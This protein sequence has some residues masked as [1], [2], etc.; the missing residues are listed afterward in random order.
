MPTII[1]IGGMSAKA[2]GFGGG[3]G[4]LGNCATYITPGTYSWVAPSGVT[5]VSVVAVGAGGSSKNVYNYCCCGVPVSIYYP[6]GGGGG[7][8]WKNNISVTPGNSYTVVVGA[9]TAQSIGGQS[10]FINCTTVAGLG[11]KYCNISGYGGGCYVGTGGGRGGNG[12]RNSCGGGKGGGGGGGYSGDGGTGCCGGGAGAGGGGGGGGYGY[13]AV[14]HAGGGGGGV[15]LYGQGTSGGSLSGDGNGRRGF[16][17]SGGQGGC[18]YAPTGGAY[19][20][21]GGQSTSTNTTGHLGSGGAV[22]IVWP[23]STRS[24]PSTNVGP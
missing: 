1:T 7:L 4:L 3:K 11:G 6:A 21:G 14:S 13:S 17:G 22:R 8:G 16:A 5:S 10:Y 15:G 23:G 19:G 18:Y 2:F 20:G 24:F 9:A 12:S